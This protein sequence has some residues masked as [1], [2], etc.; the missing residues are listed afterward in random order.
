M[1]LKK[2]VEFSIASA[3]MERQACL[4]GYEPLALVYTTKVVPVP[5]NCGGDRLDI[6]VLNMSRTEEVRY[7]ICLGR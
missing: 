4:G 3:I 2:V 5:R 7:G 1:P 6:S